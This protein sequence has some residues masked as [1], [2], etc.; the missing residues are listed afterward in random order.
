MAT[1]AGRPE[2]LS[3]LSPVGFKFLLNKLPNVEYFCQGITLPGISLMSVPLETPFTRIPYPGDRVEFQ[4]FIVRFIIDED[5]LNFT[6]IFKW[7]Q[8]LGFPES[9]EQL[10]ALK[11]S[12]PAAPGFNPVVP[13]SAN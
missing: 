9:F 11:D 12:D 4:D 6:E 7:M 2:N 1:I 5:M 10:K 13:A 3:Y 8:G